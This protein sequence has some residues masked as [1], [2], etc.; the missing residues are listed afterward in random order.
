MGRYRLAPVL[1]GTFALDG[2]SLFGIVPRPLWEKLLPPDERGR[3]ALAIRCLL[4]IDDQAGRRILVDTGIGELTDPKR[5]TTLAVKRGV[6]GLDQALQAHGLSRGDITDVVL[7]HLH[8]D[9]AGGLVRRGAGGRLEPTFPRATI[10][11]QRRNWQWAHA[12]SEH[13]AA[14]FRPEPLELLAHSSQLHLVDG[15]RELFPDLQLIVSEGHTT[16]QQLPRF[17]GDGLHLTCCGDVIPTTAHL[18]VAW[19]MAFDLRPL[20]T[21]EEK[22][23]LLAEALEEEGILFF[24]HDPAVAACRLM[25]QDGRPAF[26][27]AA[28]L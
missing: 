26:R 19:G 10:H 11:V 2:G 21:I 6:P 24:S 28:E 16:A 8:L 22:R 20:T 15:E 14:S 12:P 4:A 13:D 5:S 3:I 1:D 17:H 23:V 25:E 18:R 9:H 27:E 7:T